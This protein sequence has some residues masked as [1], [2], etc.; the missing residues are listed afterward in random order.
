M[1]RSIT[2]TDTI[3]KDIVS[4]DTSDYAYYTGSTPQN[5]YHGSDGTSYGQINLT[6]NANA[7]TYVYYIFDSFS[8]IPSGATITSVTCSCK[9]SINQTNANRVATRQAQ[10]YSGTTSKG[11]AYTVAN[12]TTA[13]SISAGSW[14]R[15]E[16]QNARLRLYAVRGTSSTTTSYYFRF[17]GATLTVNYSYQ[18]T[19]YTITA[20]STASE[21]TVTPAS[22]EKM[23]GESAQVTLNTNQNIVVTDN[24]VDVTNSLVVSG[25]DYVYTIS[26]ID[27]DHEIVVI[28]EETGQTIYTK[29]NGS[30][31]KASK[32]YVKQNGVWVEG[33]MYVKDNGSWKS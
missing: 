6:R 7:V 12:S 4:H 33:T 27:A 29:Q 31:V 24:G 26:D 13:F 23:A 11:T 5:G 25:S 15:A 32:L 9:C 20:S 8:A 18:G 19:A 1:S 21:V 14:T 3:A 17:Y 30:W 2:I 16:L 28:G 10:L 22:Q